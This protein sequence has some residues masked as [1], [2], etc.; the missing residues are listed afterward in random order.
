MVEMEVMR[1]QALVKVLTVIET[2]IA[3]KGK[4]KRIL[5]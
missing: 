3:G 5:F 1:E 4:S 2:C